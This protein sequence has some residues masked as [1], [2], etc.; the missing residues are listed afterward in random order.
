[1]KKSA[2]LALTLA[3]GL[4]VGTA[5]L[6]ADVETPRELPGGKILTAAQAK[7]LVG[8]A[9]FFD[10]RKAVNYGRGHIPGAV[11][12]PYDQKSEFSVDFDASVDRLDWS[13]LPADKG[14]PVVFYSD[15]PTGWKSYK[16]AVLA[17]REGYTNVMWFRGGTA[18]WAAAGYA[19][20]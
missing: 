20:N 2:R 9:Q 7:D 12:L 19:F 16:A 5:A 14:A 3:L 10:M 1:M 8:K 4:L 6:A 11:A 18:E 17:I 13:Q 15:G